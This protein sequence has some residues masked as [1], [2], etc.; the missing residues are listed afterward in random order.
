M[1]I[2]FEQRHLLLDSSR[3]RGL[4]LATVFLDRVLFSKYHYSR[5]TSAR[6]VL[7]PLLFD[8]LIVRDYVRYGMPVFSFY[9]SHFVVDK[10]LRAFAYRVEFV[11]TQLS[12]F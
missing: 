4:S 6:V 9:A 3:D 2:S 8:F 5:I 1:L 7:S 11:D 10:G 12:L